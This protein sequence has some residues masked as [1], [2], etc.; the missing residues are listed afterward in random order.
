MKKYERPPRIGTGNNL[1]LGP[2][3]LSMRYARRARR[4]VVV[5]IHRIQADKMAPLVHEIVVGVRAEVLLPQIDGKLP[6][7]SHAAESSLDVVIAHHIEERH[8]QPG[9]EAFKLAPLPAQHPLVRPTLDEIADRHHERRPQKIQSGDR[10]LEV[11]LPL[12]SRPVGH[13]R[14]MKL[15]RIVKERLVSPRLDAREA[16]GKTGTD[17]ACAQTNSQRHNDAF[18]LRVLSLPESPVPRFKTSNAIS[19][20]LKKRT[21]KPAHCPAPGDTKSREREERS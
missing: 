11:A 17:R 20:G 8:I 4:I 19:P 2:V 15:L 13:H 16:M 7:G 10:F 14:K 21:G 3:D 1:P 5:V 18:H 9:D 12:A 6:S